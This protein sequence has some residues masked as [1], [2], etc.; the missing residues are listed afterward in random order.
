[1]LEIEH[2]ILSRTHCRFLPDC[3]QLTG[4]VWGWAAKFRQTHKQKCAN[5]NMKKHANEYCRPDSLQ[6]LEKLKHATTWLSDGCRLH[7]LIAAGRLSDS[8]DM[9]QIADLFHHSV[10]TGS[11]ALPLTLSAQRHKFK[12]ELRSTALYFQTILEFAQDMG[13]NRKRQKAQ[14]VL[15]LGSLAL[16]S[17]WSMK[18]ESVFVWFGFMLASDVSWSPRGHVRDQVNVECMVSLV[19]AIETSAKFN[20]YWH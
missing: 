11:S 6:E 4:K 18:N 8:Q 2:V 17:P 5:T 20:H 12:T 3:A 9:E 10:E 13:W 19:R 7:G 14:M 1:M 16:A 15:Q